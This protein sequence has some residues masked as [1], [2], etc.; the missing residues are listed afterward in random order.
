VLSPEHEFAT[1]RAIGC[2]NR[3]IYRVITGQAPITRFSYG[4]IDNRSPNLQQY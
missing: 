4:V 1:L 2:S 3:Y